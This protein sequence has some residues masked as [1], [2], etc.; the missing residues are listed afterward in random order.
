MLITLPNQG[1]SSIEINEH[2]TEST[3]RETKE[4]FKRG[5]Q[6]AMKEVVD[7]SERESTHGHARFF[8]G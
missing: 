6:S 8:V 2:M 1:F 3:K 4:P 7:S 5:G